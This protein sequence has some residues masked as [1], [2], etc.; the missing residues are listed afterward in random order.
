MGSI[1]AAA[2][3]EQ[4]KKTKD[5]AQITEMQESISF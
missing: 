3:R 5:I 4:V 2:F 1:L